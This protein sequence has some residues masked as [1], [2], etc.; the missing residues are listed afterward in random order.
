MAMTDQNQQIILLPKQKERK[1]E[2]K[3]T[4]KLVAS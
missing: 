4:D 3:E 2:I 1:K